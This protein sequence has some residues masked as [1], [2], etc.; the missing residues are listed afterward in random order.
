NFNF[1]LRGIDPLTFVFFIVDVFIDFQFCRKGILTIPRNLGVSLAGA[2]KKKT[3]L[4]LLGGF[5]IWL[6]QF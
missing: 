2:K 3:L 5:R 4:L 6:M 1:P